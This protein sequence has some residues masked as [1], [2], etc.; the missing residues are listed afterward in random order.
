MKIYIIAIIL[1]FF[2]CNAKE[3]KNEQKSK[4]NT[5]VLANDTTV[6]QL[7]EYRGN[8]YCEIRYKDYSGDVIYYYSNGKPQ[9]KMHYIKNRL[10]GKTCFYYKN[11]KVKTELEFKN[12]IPDGFIYQY[13]EHFSWF[14]SCRRWRFDYHKIRGDA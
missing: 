4:N 8:K 1:F 5:V 2:S 14:N 13:Y 6:T 12:D 10:N 9:R 7:Y 3:N 11:G